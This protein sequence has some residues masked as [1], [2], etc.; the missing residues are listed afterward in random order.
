LP[1]ETVGNPL[2]A[3]RG[4]PYK[5]KEERKMPAFFL[6]KKKQ[7]IMRKS[8]LR[9]RG[10]PARME[11]NVLS[12]GEG[13]NHPREKLNQSGKKN[14]QKG[15]YH[16]GG[17]KKVGKKSA[18]FCNLKKVGKDLPQRI[19]GCQRWKLVELYPKR[20]KWQAGRLEGSGGGEEI[21][22]KGE[23]GTDWRP[24]TKGSCNRTYT[25]IVN[26]KTY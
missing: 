4:S 26:Q 1:N 9:K 6:S 16:Q 5:F 18:H 10:H 8:R 17:R 14:D 2:R 19:Y 22:E 23:V 11:G 15:K 7:L 24:S 12:E 20:S 25:S 21:W 3:K 13:D